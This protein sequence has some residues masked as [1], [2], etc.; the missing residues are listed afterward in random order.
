MTRCLMRI[1]PLAHL[2]TVWCDVK[3]LARNGEVWCTLVVDRGEESH[4]YC[5]RPL[6]T[7]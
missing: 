4:Y 3:T 2:A 5:E 7:C 1:S 6:A